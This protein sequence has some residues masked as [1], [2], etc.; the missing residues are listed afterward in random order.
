MNTQEID[1]F[2]SK[3]IFSQEEMAKF[4]SLVPF[5]DEEEMFIL[6]LK[7]SYGLEV[8]E[9]LLI[10]FVQLYLLRFAIP[11]YQICEKKFPDSKNILFLRQ[12]LYTCLIGRFVDDLVDKDSQM[13]KTYESILL[14]Q[15]YYARILKLLSPEDNSKF[16]QYLLDSTRYKSPL[17]ESTLSFQE[18][19]SDVYERI[20]YFFYEAEHFNVQDQEILKSYVGILLGGLDISDLIADNYQIS[21][22]TVV[23]NYVYHK[24]TNDEGKLLFNEDLLSFY[25]DMKATLNAETNQLLKHC[26]EQD[27][28][29][30]ANIL[31]GILK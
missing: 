1:S 6:D 16:H 12:I 29:Y 17:I 11:Y 28:F 9:D 31:K 20:K 4:D 3:Y 14:F 22:S 18:I 25:S 15:K 27:L 8:R 26:E 7:K 24:Y 10:L 19:K 13:F 5:L 23:S 30:T 2:G 21:S